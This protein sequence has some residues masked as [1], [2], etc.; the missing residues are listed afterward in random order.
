MISPA[1]KFHDSVPG[2]TTCSTTIDPKYVNLSTSVNSNLNLVEFRH[3]GA[4][5]LSADI[6]APRRA[7]MLMLCQCQCFEFYHS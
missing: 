2:K 4:G 1:L 5:E 7:C 3:S 6:A